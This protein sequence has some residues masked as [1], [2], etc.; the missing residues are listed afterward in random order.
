[1]G[2][3]ISIP[4]YERTVGQR[5]AFEGER[6]AECGTIAF[7]PKGA[8]PDCRN[9]E[10]ETVDLSGDGTIYSYTVLSPGGAPP[11]FAGQARAEGRYVVAIVELD[12]GPRITAQV[13]DVDPE[14]VDIGMPVT[15]QIRRIYEEEGVVRY[16]FK[17]VPT[18]D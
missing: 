16:G 6:C 13:T 12:E 11:E 17:F 9:T 14:S 1:M 8:C 5:L 18:S 15:G 10:F 3:H 2:A 4:M 7:P